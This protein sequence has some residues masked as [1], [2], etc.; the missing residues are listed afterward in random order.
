MKGEGQYEEEVEEGDS[1]VCDKSAELWTVALNRRKKDKNPLLHP[2]TSASGAVSNPQKHLQQLE[3]QHKGQIAENKHKEVEIE[4][5]SQQL[6]ALL[7]E[8]QTQNTKHNMEHSSLRLSPHPHTRK[9][10]QKSTKRKKD[11]QVVT[12]VAEQD[13]PLEQLS[14]AKIVALLRNTS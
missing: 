5:L 1:S 8:R 4:L 9:P 2:N 6:Q 11:S 13:T 12:E 3:Q 10:T 14:Q 7:E